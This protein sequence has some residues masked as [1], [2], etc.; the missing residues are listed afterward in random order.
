M[1]G[2]YY[3]GT[4]GS[5]ALGTAALGTD[6]ALARLE[7]LAPGEL[8]RVP[9]A[10]ELLGAAKVRARFAPIPLDAFDRVA[11]VLDPLA[12]AT[13][14]HLLRLSYGEGR[15]H[16]RAGKRDLMGRLGL[17]ERRLLR[18]LDELVARGFAR[19][20]HRDNRGTLYRVYLP[21]EAF[22]EGVG[23]DVLLGRAAPQAVE[24]PA[25]AAP[26]PAPA[27]APASAPTSLA[28]LARDLCAARGHAADGAP[29]ERAFAEVTEM[30]EEGHTREQVR[31]CIAVIARRAARA[32]GTGARP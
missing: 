18:V 13:W 16:C 12:Q 19:P 25:A 24:S 6:D 21:A 29:L 7:S 26:S 27:R 11:G 10:G 23:D 15:N 20:L 1:G 14:F 17:S 2:G 30:L 3:K 32:A 28:A 4:R 8:R 31:A 5:A 22:G 9:F